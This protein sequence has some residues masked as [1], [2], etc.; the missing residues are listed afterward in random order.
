MYLYIQSRPSDLPNHRLLYQLFLYINVGMNTFTCLHV[1][2]KTNSANLNKRVFITTS[3][4]IHIN[5]DPLY[6]VAT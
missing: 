1:N 6:H 3:E 4:F 2:I 5:S